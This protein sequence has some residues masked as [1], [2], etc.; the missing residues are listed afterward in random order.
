[1]MS[2]GIIDESWKKKCDEMICKEYDKSALWCGFYFLG[3]VTD[4]PGKKKPIV[5]DR[6]IRQLK[7]IYRKVN[8]RCQISEINVECIDDIRMDMEDSSEILEM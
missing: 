8:A 4:L 6:I 5:R 7:P 3:D 1:M 2:Y